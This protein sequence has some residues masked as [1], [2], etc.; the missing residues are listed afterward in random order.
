MIDIHTH[1]LFNTDDGVENIEQSIGQI[2]E[3]IKIGIDTICVTPH[4]LEP[5]YTKTKIQNRRKLDKIKMELKK[6]R[7]NVK[8]YLGNEI[9]ISENI[10]EILDNN[11]ISTI[12]NSNYILLELPRNIELKNLKELIEKIINSGK[13]VIIAHPERYSYV[14]KNIKYFD[15]LI[16]NGNVY[17]QGNYGSIIGFFG[18]EAQ[19]TIIKLIKQTKLHV[20]ASD[21][22]KNN[23]Y[24]EL[25]GIIKKI[26][27]IANSKYMHKL[28]E[29]NPRKII[30]NEDIIIEQKK[31]LKFK[32]GHFLR[33][34]MLK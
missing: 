13:K 28:L 23:L 31:T 16:K 12:A 21:I 2:Q 3:A 17:L 4:Y 33:K 24:H 6:R 7:I 10:N 15:D 27:K 26:K 30:N 22:H 14:Q 8:L 1:L 32:I 20:L 29:E 25:P 34:Y 11:K 18:N 9:Y 5:E 19:K